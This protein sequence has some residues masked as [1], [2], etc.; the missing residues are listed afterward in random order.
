MNDRKFSSR[1]KFFRSH[2][3]AKCIFPSMD[4]YRRIRIIIRKRGRNFRGHT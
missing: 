4:I 1:Y 2:D 3:S